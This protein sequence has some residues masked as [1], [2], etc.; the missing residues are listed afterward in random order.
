V[1]SIGSYFALSSQVQ[2]DVDAVCPHPFYLNV[3]QESF[4]LL[5]LLKIIWANPDARCEI[6][7]VHTGRFLDSSIHSSQ[8]HVDDGRRFPTNTMN[9]IL[10]TLGTND[11]L[12][13]KQYA[14]YAK[15]LVSV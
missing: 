12:N 2:I 5:P 14:K 6:T 3:Y 1:T 11:A 10:V 13:I 8:R 15:F 7:F 4:D 9:N